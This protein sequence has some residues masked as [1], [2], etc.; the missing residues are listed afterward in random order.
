MTITGPSCLGIA[1]LLTFVPITNT[2]SSSSLLPGRGSLDE[3]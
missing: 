3:D 1:R 2:A